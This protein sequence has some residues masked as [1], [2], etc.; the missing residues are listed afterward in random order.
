MDLREMAACLAGSRFSGFRTDRVVNRE[1]ATLRGPAVATIIGESVLEAL[2][3]LLVVLVEVFLIQ[4][5]PAN[6]LVGHRR[7][8]GCPIFGD[9]IGAP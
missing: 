4:V 3:V 7:S 1:S 9:E 2:V 5:S 8:V 6:F